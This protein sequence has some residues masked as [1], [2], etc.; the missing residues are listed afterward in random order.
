MTG[1]GW[2]FWLAAADWLR[3]WR[4]PEQPTARRG[5]A[6]GAVNDYFWLDE[7]MTGS[8]WLFWAI[9]ASHCLNQSAAAN[10]E[11]HPLGGENFFILKIHPLGGEFS[12]FKIFF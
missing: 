6:R 4:Q 11:S 8:G 2:L 1:S 7:T 3:Q 12:K 9:R 5:A 10:Q